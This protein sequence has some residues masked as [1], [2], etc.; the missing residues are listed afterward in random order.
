MVSA[1][2][3]GCAVD[4][5]TL[6]VALARRLLIALW[7]LARDIAAMGES[8]TSNRHRKPITPERRE[9]KP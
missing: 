5:Q 7:R 9:A 6:I 8:G 1:A 3:G 4:A 2:N